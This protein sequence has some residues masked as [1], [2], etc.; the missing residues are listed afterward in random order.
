MIFHLYASFL[1]FKISVVSLYR[2]YTAGRKLIF[3]HLE[4]KRH[5]ISKVNGLLLPFGPPYK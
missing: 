4:A 1:C 3:L 2:L 5:N